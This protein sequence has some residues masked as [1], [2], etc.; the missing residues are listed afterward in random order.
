MGLTT[1]GFPCPSGS[2]ARR[3]RTTSSTSPKFETSAMK[4]L[5]SASLLVSSIVKLSAASQ[6]TR[7]PARWVADHS[8]P[9]WVALRLHLDQ[10]QFALEVLLAGDVLDVDDVHQLQQLVRDLVDD[11]VVAGRDQRQARDRRDRRSARRSATRCCSRGSRRVRRRGSG[12]PTSFCSVTEMMWRMAR[13]GG[14]PADR[15]AV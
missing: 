7:P 3:E 6:S 12:R 11:R 1:P 15:S 5:I 8:E 14:P 10:Q 4:R 9:T 13:H 2:R